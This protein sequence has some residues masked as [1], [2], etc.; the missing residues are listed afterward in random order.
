MSSSTKPFDSLIPMSVQFAKDDAIE[1][2]SYH[3]QL[4]E[5]CESESEP[6]LRHL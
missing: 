4:V 6:D 5:W 3:S 1:G 2:S